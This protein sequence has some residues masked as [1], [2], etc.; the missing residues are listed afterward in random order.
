MTFAGGVD[1]LAPR[2][3][4]CD[5]RTFRDYDQSSADFFEFLLTLRAQL[6]KCRRPPRGRKELESPVMGFRIARFGLVLC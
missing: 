3:V 1:R 6:R 5:F 4:L 2:F